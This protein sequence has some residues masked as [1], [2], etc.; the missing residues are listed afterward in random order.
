MR[1]PTL[2]FLGEMVLPMNSLFKILAVIALVW[3]AVL[4]LGSVFGILGK[5]IWVGILATVAGLLWS[6]IKRD[7]RPD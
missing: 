1:W 6:Y 3:L 5:L 4:I 2:G 7:G